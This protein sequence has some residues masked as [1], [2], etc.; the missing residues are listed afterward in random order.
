[1]PTARVISTQPAYSREFDDYCHKLKNLSERAA[2]YILHDPQ[3]R[4]VYRENIRQAIAYLR[5]EFYRKRSSAEDYY[6]YR[7][8]RDNALNGLVYL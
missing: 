4:T 8:G 6:T 2:S 3:V 5:E 1:M 7:E